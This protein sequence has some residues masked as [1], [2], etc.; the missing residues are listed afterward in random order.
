MRV[1][2]LVSNVK[3]IDA[4]TEWS[5]KDMPPKHA[6]IYPK[7]KPM[8]AGWTWRSARCVTAT[9]DYILVAECNPARDNWKAMLILD[10][11]TGHSVV[12][13][14]EYHG[15]HPG[16]HA[17]SDC[18]RSGIE[19][20]PKSIDNLLRI[21]TAKSFH[22]RLAAWTENTFWEAAKRFF[23]IEHRKGPLGI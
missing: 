11:G 23:R 4:E 8:R 20:G 14:F 22:R 10:T 18:D 19:V 1:R 2:H 16:L 13:R 6:P 12:G 5:V 15:S 7:T 3:Y 9:R 17:H 21:P